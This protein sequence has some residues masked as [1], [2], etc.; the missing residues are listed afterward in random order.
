MTTD[1][2]IAEIAAE[3]K[4]QIEVEGWSAEHDDEHVDGS[5]AAAAACYAHPKQIFT[6]A[7]HSDPRGDPPMPDTYSRVQW[8]WPKS[9]HGKWFKMKGR[10][11]DLIRAGALIIAEIERLDRKAGQPWLKART[12][13]EH[14]NG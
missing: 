5:L 1:K 14:G 9:W 12:Q 4:R 13:E 10:R 6:A 3:R 8:A 11:R 2:V 7:V